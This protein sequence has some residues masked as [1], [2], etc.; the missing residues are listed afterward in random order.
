M[1]VCIMRV[2][3]LCEEKGRKGSADLQGKSDAPLLAAS[4]TNNASLKQYISEVRTI[5]YSFVSFYF[6]AIQTTHFL[7]FDRYTFT[8]GVR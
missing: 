2:L 1:H 7:S 8:N 6:P 4:D 5:L 3:C